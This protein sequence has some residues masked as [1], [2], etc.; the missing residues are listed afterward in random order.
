MPD[1]ISKKV[2]L[3]DGAMG[4]ILTADPEVNSFLPE[5]LNL[6][7]PEKILAI[8]RAYVEAGAQ[9]IT[10]N[11]FSANPIKLNSSR[12]SLQE[13]LDAAIELA[14]RAAGESSCKSCST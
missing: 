14:R 1:L 8:H 13:V 11:S 6:L 2:Q 4:T 9:Y 3:F 7:F 10:T 5:E 12:F